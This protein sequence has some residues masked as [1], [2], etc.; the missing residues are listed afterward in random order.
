MFKDIPASDV[1]HHFDPTY[2]DQGRGF[3]VFIAGLENL[4]MSLVSTEDERIRS[5]IISRMH[6]TV[7]NESGGPD[8]DDPTTSIMP[9]SDGCP[10]QFS[11][12][13]FPGGVMYLPANSGERIEQM[14]HNNPGPIWD[15][16]QNRL[17]K[18]SIIGTGW[19]YSIW[20]NESQGTA[21]RGEVMKCR[22]AVTRRQ[23]DLYYGAKR[24]MAWAYSV[25]E[26]SGRVPLLDQPTAWDFSRP[27]RL[28]VDDGREAKAELDEV[29][30][31]TRL[32]SEV[33]GAR[34]EDE[35]SFYRQRAVSVAKRKIIAAQTAAEMSKQYGFEV[36]IDD[37]E[38]FMQ[39][40]NELATAP[41]VDDTAPEV[42]PNQSN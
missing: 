25:F 30:T 33:L 4:K 9:S 22:R 1:V 35:D 13:M 3:P 26:E 6:L 38:M 24:A 20:A 34:G 42:P 23:R 2:S 15:G 36:T 28:T 11:T 14:E 27:P 8:P 16:L 10:G 12:R 41:P 19:S 29:V 37:R 5:Q 7:F 21:V 40:P 31:G 17:L 39:T 18:D 32:L